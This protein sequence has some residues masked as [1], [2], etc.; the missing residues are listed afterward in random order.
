MEKVLFRV[1]SP[2]VWKMSYSELVAL[3]YGKGGGHAVQKRCCCRACTEQAVLL[4]GKGG[5]AQNR[6]FRC[7]VKVVLH[8]IGCFAVW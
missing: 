4:C 7:V 8:R 5:V 1:G 3:L 2:V 6:L